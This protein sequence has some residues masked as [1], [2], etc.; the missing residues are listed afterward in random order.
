MWRPIFMWGSQSWLPILAAA[1]FEPAT[2][3]RSN[4]KLKHAPPMRRSRLKTA[5]LQSRLSAGVPR[6]ARRARRAKDSSPV[7]QHWGKDDPA[8]APGRGGRTDA[9]VPSYA[10]FRGWQI[11]ARLLP[12]AGAGAGALGSCLMP[13]WLGLDFD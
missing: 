9:A 12:T 11:G 5:K 3:L 10:P 7:R 2:E 6:M 13:C 8:S 1:G 4:G